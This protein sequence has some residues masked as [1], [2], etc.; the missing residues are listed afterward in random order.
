MWDANCD[1]SRGVL[2]LIAPVFQSLL[3]L[4]PVWLI[5]TH[6][7]PTHNWELFLKAL[8][9]A[10]FSVEFLL[11]SREGQVCCIGCSMHYRTFSLADTSPPIA[12]SVAS[13]CDHQK[14]PPRAPKSLWKALFIT[15]AKINSSKHVVKHLIPS[16]KPLERFLSP[17]KNAHTRKNL[18]K[19]K[20]AN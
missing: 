7:I 12:S 5:P 10:L 19:D 1:R 13:H 18:T 11:A 20:L 8:P 4:L 2:Q 16:N 6:M 9:K 3:R 15:R 17:T 14:C